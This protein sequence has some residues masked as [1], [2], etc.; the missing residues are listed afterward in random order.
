MRAVVL[1]S[2]YIVICAK[3]SR[4]RALVVERH[5]VRDSSVD[6]RGLVI[7]ETISILYVF[8]HSQL[9]LDTH[10]RICQGAIDH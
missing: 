2:S 4:T 10:E 7:A 9:V 1:I 5:D 8:Y 3:S 6:E